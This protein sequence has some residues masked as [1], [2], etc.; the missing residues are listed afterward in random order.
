MKTD[1]KDFPK[2]EAIF[3]LTDV[4]KWEMNVQLFSDLLISKNGVQ[5]TVRDIDEPQ[6]VEFHLCC[7]DLI[8]KDDFPIPRI[9][10]GAFWFS[11]EHLFMMKY[12]RKINYSLYGK[13]STVI[14]EHASKLNFFI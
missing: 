13:P 7:K 8:Y 11:L 1:I 4:V 2:F 12:K 3:M 6:S 14:F 10:A 9:G 5:G